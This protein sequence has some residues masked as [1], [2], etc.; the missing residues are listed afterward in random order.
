MVTHIPSPVHPAPES[1]TRFVWIHSTGT[2]RPPTNHSGSYSS[3]ALPVSNALQ[4]ERVRD[5]D[6]LA[7]SEKS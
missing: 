7:E 1:V 4:D 6:P 2:S 5:R 3:G